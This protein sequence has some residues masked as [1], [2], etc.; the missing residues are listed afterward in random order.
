M[1]LMSL[2]AR[3]TLDKDQYDKG[4]EEAEKDA[5]NLNI[6]T[7]V[8]PKTDNTQFQAGVKEAE[9]TGNWFREVM[10]GVWSGVKDAI[11]TT[12]ILGLVTGIVGAMK[13][14]I[15]LAI[16]DGKAISDGAKNLQ[17]STRA[18]QEYEYVLG[19]SNLKVKDLSKAMDGLGKI[20]SGDLTEK[21]KKYVSELEEMGFVADKTATNEQNLSNMM[22]A[23]ADYGGTDKG[24]IIDWLFGNNQ[25]WTGYFSQTSAEIEG[26]KQEAEELGQIMSDESVQNAAKF[27]DATEK[28]ADRLEA[29]KRSFGEGILP[30]IT[31]AINKLMMIVDFF[32]GQDTRTSSEKFVDEESK[33]QSKIKDIE[34]TRITADTLAKTL[35][36]MGDTSV[37]DATQLAIWKGTAQSLIELIPTLS[38]VIDVENGT[39]NESSEGI[40]ELIKTYSELEK[41]T[42][43]QTSKAERQNIIDQKRNKITEEAVKAN[44]ALAEAEGK[45]KDAI[46]AYNAVLAKYNI[47]G[48]G[49]DATEA[50]LQNAQQR[51]FSTAALDEYGMSQA[52]SELNAASKPV[53]DALNEARLAQ[54]EVDKLTADV[55]EGTEEFNAWI[56]AEGAAYGGVSEEAAAAVSAVEGVI[57]ALDGIP[58]DVT[59]FIHVLYDQE[60]APRAIGDHYVPYDN[61]PALLHRGERV[62]TATE[63]RRGTGD[64]IDYTRLEDSIVASIR[65]GMADAQVTAVVTDRQ[66]AKGSNR[67]N[68]NELDS[69]RFVP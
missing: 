21:Q 69:R 34:A 64:G 30:I 7:P 52:V 51:L 58:T 56:E 22:K 28:L 8:I 13:Q 47:E 10:S 49:Y 68:G 38:G 39:I 67:H 45:R 57:D 24:A 42:A 9:D 15:D 55:A 1:D 26:L 50:D 20:L 60:G 29:I 4:L 33:Y 12:G 62:L 37:M 61:F 40:S 53:T 14:G 11:V 44:N 46:D 2:L 5:K 48:V 31:E 25:N 35:M 59:T 66:V 16:R 17:I 32:T 36:N 3:L 43:Y 54:A 41:A 65:A 6:P 19:K 18:Y 27:T 23:L 63:A